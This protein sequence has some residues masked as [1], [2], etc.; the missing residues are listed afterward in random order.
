MKAVVYARTARKQ[1]KDANSIQAQIDACQLCAKARKYQISFVFSD[2]GFSG[3]NLNR[4]ALSKMREYIAHHPIDMV[5]V[6]DLS[7]LT[8]FMAD[9]LVIESE[10]AGHNVRLCIVPLSQGDEI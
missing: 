2:A 10:L 9:W 7:R 5:I 3:A 1:P 6:Q 4:P 8:R